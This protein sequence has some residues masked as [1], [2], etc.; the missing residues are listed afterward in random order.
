MPVQIACIG[1]SQISIS[2]AL[3]L[4]RHSKEFKFKGWDPLLDARVA[5]DRHK[6]FEPVTRNPQDAARGADLVLLSLP[7][8]ELFSTLQVLDATMGRST[9]L[10]N[11][12]PMATHTQRVIQEIFG[13][14][15]P[16]LS[17]FPALRAETMEDCLFGPASA[18]GDLFDNNLIFIA[19]SQDASPAMLDLAVNLAVL[20]GGQPIFTTPQ[21]LD[22]LIAANLLLPQL[23]A[24]ALMNT[25]AKQPSWQEGGKLAGGSLFHTTLPL[26][27]L[28][29]NEAFGFT[30]RA[31]KENM[32][33]L[34]EDLIRELIHLR[35]LLKDENAEKISELFSQV[36]DSR[37]KWLN[38]RQKPQISASLATS[39]PGKEEA[40]KR[41][42]KMG[43]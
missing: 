28:F 13:K 14:K 4:S 38:E 29:E 18:R 19:E 7:S 22:G 35:D 8:D 16:F 20:M 3:S 40:L 5:A 2:T 21:E 11:L 23:S 24:A 1:L 25:T 6:V 31:N 41:L 9:A 36:L 37:G 42:L 15:I 27:D 43:K 39:I 26:T 32:V 34:I 30:A 17:I 12:S 33:R 10:I